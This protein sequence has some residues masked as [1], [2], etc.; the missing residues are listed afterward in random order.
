MVA[1]SSIQQ[2]QVPNEPEL[3]DLLN[4]LRKQIGLDFNC[5]HVANL[6]SFDPLK[7]TGKATINYKRT[8]FEPDSAGNYVPVLEDYPVL[9]DCPVISLGGG[10]AALTFPF[11][12]GD[13]CLVLFNDRDIDNWFNGS[14]N[15]PVATPR[16]HSFADA[17]LLPGLRSLANV[18]VDYNTDAAEL[19]DKAG[20]NKVSVGPDGVVVTNGN[21]TATFAN[22][23]SLTIAI[24]NNLVVLDDSQFG[25]ATVSGGMTI[26]DNGDIE[27]ETGGVGI[28]WTNTGTV[29]FE[30][31]TGELIGALCDI[32]SN[33][34]AGGYPFLADPA[35]LPILLSF[36]E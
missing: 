20:G 15:S 17:I 16:L 23:G 18:L 30:N 27:F 2:N 10:N 28:R 11:T 13:E 1:Q 36:R 3:K 19:R 4:L 32:M 7:Q 31:P 34:T 29:A 6:E 14:S 9:V 26:K 22:D 24:G 33:S 21:M 12:E 8:F 35:S 5:H 25:I